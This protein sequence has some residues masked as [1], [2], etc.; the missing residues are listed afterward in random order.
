MLRKM[1]INGI[2]RGSQSIRVNQSRC[3]CLRNRAFECSRCVSCCDV[4]AVRIDEGGLF[5]NESLCIECMLCVSECPTGSFEIQG[6][7]FPSDVAKLK[8]IPKPVLACNR[9]PGLEAHVR[10]SCLGFLSEEHLAFLVISMEQGIQLNLTECRKCS[11]GF[12]VSHIRKRLHDI[13]TRIS[14]AASEKIKLVENSEDLEYRDVSYNRR[15]F[16]KALTGVSAQGAQRFLFNDAPDRKGYAYS[17]KKIPVKRELLNRI[18]GSSNNPVGV[19]ILESF[20]YEII[21]EQGCDHCFSC[22]AACPSGA[23][24]PQKWESGKR[25]LFNSSL[26]N[27]CGLCAVFCRKGALNV[28]RGFHGAHPFQFMSCHG[29]REAMVDP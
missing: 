10:G 23:L 13:D 15:D 6:A 18:V 21:T 19:D 27:G 26:C 24:H 28:S 9:K 1:I 17:E 7:D 2:M 25:L 11:N 3:L 5:I 20:Y 22:V 8:G 4:D 16:F 14:V 29:E 12:T